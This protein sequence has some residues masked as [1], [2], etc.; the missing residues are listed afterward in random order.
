MN[1]KVVVR[2]SAFHTPQRKTRL[3]LASL[4]VF[5]GLLSQD[6]TVLECNFGPLGTAMDGPSDW[7]GCAFETGPWWNYSEE[8]RSDILALLDQARRGQRVSSERLY[9][10]LDGQMGAMILSLVPLFAPYGQADAILVIAIDVTERRREYE[11]SEQ[12]AHDMAHRLRNS[13]TIMR[14]LAS[15][16]DDRNEPRER[17]SR[18]MSLIRHGHS[19]SYKYLFFDIPLEDVIKT[20]VGE[21]ADIKVL[22]FG[23]VSIPSRFTEIMLLALGELAMS[24]QGATVTTELKGEAGLTIQWREKSARDHLP[25]GLQKAL[26]VA[27][28]ETET[29][30]RVTMTNNNAGFVWTL[31]FTVPKNPDLDGLNVKG[32]QKPA[33]S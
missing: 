24:S 4:P 12:I 19:L 30:G 21:Q 5:A 29:G 26:L 17:L 15:R 11:S 6:G 27:G 20:A 1:D 31:Q 28:I 9:R 2:P 32:L 25:T 3:L 22:P 7:V 18:R 13:F 16:A 33:A 8:S 10:R 23:A 14:T